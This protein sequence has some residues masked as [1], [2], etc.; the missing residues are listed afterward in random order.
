M[1]EI[2]KLYKSYGDNE[3]LRASIKAAEAKPGSENPMMLR[4]TF[5]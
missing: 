5:T 2:K 1:I 3:V 4:C